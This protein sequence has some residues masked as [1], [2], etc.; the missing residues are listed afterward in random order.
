MTVV[1][2]ALVRDGLVLAQQRAFPAEA[3]GKWEFPGGRV[4]AGESDV[5][6]LVRECA[7]ELGCV[8]RVGDFVKTVL[9]PSGRE[10]RLYAGVAV[11][12]E[13][14]AVEHTAVRWLSSDELA[15]V[16]WL[17]ADLDFLDEVRALLG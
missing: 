14:E 12:G 13:P 11:E 8:V 15:A 7:E 17:P 16:D 10:L 1:A 2:V 9:L 5:D 3:A 4:E 6:A